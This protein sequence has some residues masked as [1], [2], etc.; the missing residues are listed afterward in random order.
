MENNLPLI[1]PV[2]QTVLPQNSNFCFICGKKIKEPPVSTTI[3]RQIALYALSFFLPPLGLWPA[4]KYLCQEDQ[5]SKIIG[6]VCVVLTILS[7]VLTI[8]V[9]LELIQ[10]LNKTLQTQLGGTDLY[11][12]IPGQN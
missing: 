1:C 2:C 12:Q 4:I 9:S 3:L 8:W 10:T 5:K 6:A 11:L 7:T